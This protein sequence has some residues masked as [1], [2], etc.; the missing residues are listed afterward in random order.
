MFAFTTEG[1]R[2]FSYQPFFSDFGPLALHQIHLFVFVALGH[3]DGHPA[4]V[5]FFV[6]SNPQQTAN[7]VLLVAAFRVIHLHLSPDDALSPFLP[8]LPRTRAYRDASSFP[9]TFEL[10]VSSCIH[11]LARAVGTGWYDYGHFDPAIWAD[12][13]RIERGD[14]NW[15]I[16]G[17]LLA[18]ASPY[19]TNVV[20]GFRV[21]TPRDLIPTLRELGIDTIVRLNNRTYDE[22]AFTDAGFRHI[23]M[24]FPDGTCPPDSILDRF[25]ELI[26]SPAVVALHC[27]AGL[28]RTGT[29]AGCHLIKSFGFSAMEAIGW[30]RIC[31]PGSVIGSQQ[32]FLVRYY[33]EMRRPAPL[34]SPA[35]PK[36]PNLSIPKKDGMRTAVGARQRIVTKQIRAPIAPRGELFGPLHVRAVPVTPQVPQPRKLH[37]AQNNSRKTPR[38]GT[39]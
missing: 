31:R 37:R 33:Q 13:E 38:K 22:A 9:S 15:L 29:L 19:Q 32:Q 39:L 12:R 6:S 18:L 3:L 21:C 11:G 34:P 27:K 10:T 25:L 17:K 24:F 30:I 8:I 7:G 16:P 5:Q 20:Q 14:M 26:E 2:R 4:G 36:R 23:E 28:G 35:A 1:D